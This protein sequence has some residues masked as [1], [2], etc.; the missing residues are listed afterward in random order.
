MSKVRTRKRGKTWSYAFE[1]GRDESGKRKVIEKGGFSSPGEAY[2]AGIEAFASWKHGNIGIT[3]ERITLKDFLES[4]L[5]SVAKENTRPTTARVYA[6]V[7]RE[8]IYPQL[9]SSII[10]DIT[11]AHVDSWIRTLAKRG[12]AH[13]TITKARVLLKQALDY[14]VYP[15]QLI[16]NNPVLYIKV[17]KKAPKDIIKRTIITPEIFAG[18]M[19]EF[20]FGHPIHIP[21]MLMYHT[22]MRIGEAIGLT[23]DNVDLPARLIRVRKQIPCTHG[24]AH[25]VYSEPKTKTSV[26]DIPISQQLADELERW[27]ARQQ[28]AERAAGKSYS[29]VFVSPEGLIEQ[30]S[31]GLLL[32][33]PTQY[34]TGLIPQNLERLQP[35]CTRDNGRLVLADV[36]QRRLR[37]HGL[38]AHSF[39]HTHATTLIE[40]GAS[41]KGVAARLGHSTTFLTQ[42]LYTHNTKKMAQDTEEI[43]EKALENM[44]TKS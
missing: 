34:D 4:W 44:Q 9:G 11:P 43:F 33:A 17:P 23:W 29:H 40:S 28:E 12:L 36:V 20:P 7:A 22:G 16:Q 3:S 2:E 25:W 32:A 41:P 13:K 15:A 37:Q 18:L 21:L 6:Y 31:A 27:R 1:V 19:Q 8:L 26:R 14:A 38:N 24:H 30:F 35:V 42:D 5:S 10:Q 39:R